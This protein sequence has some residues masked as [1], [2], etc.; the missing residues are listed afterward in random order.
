[1]SRGSAEHLA[2]F[3][4]CWFDRA[5]RSARRVTGGD[6]ALCLDVVQEAMMRTARR[7]RA[8]KTSAEL[9]AWFERVVRSCAIDRMRADIRRL[10]AEGAGVRV[11]GGDGPEQGVAERL[12]W[13]EDALS[14]ADE[15]DRRLIRL[16][17]ADGATLAQAGEATGLSGPAAHGR[18]RRLLDSL[19]R[20]GKERFGDE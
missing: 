15:V 16:R 7:V 4:R 10:R 18:L 13:R 19:R 9:G 20:V 17:F 12:A 5:Y 2:E 11:E 14:R 6:E 1:M 8:V 3:Y